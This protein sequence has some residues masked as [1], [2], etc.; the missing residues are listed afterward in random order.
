MAR[1]DAHTSPH[2]AHWQDI[3]ALLGKMHTELLVKKLRRQERR[4]QR[5]DRR[6]GVAR[7]RCACC[8]LLRCHT[9][10]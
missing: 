10:Q 9:V 2:I 6:C 1:A 5:E 7:A 4:Q 8:A 3:N